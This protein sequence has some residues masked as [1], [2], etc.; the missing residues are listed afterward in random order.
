MMS[1]W[2]TRRTM[3]APGRARTCTLWGAGAVFLMLKMDSG[4]RT[5]ERFYVAIAALVLLG[6]VDSQVQRLVRRRMPFSLATTVKERRYSGVSLVLM[7]VAA[8]V[9]IAL[10]W[11]LP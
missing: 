10:A 6:A 1:R 8:V 7:L 2:Y 3:P 11:L 9:L 5:Q 4:S